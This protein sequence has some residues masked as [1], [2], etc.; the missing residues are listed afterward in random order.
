MLEM[1]ILMIVGFRI[2]EGLEKECIQRLLVYG[3]DCLVLYE[4]VRL[5]SRLMDAQHLFYP[6]MC[7]DWQLGWGAKHEGG[8]RGTNVAESSL[9]SLTG[10]STLSR[11]HRAVFEAHAVDAVTALNLLL[12][13]VLAV[14]GIC[15]KMRVE[16]RGA[17][18]YLVMD[19]CCE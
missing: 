7:L 10:C 8:E 6:T 15:V 14:A 17:A 2:Q 19:G 11:G 18:D 5:T 4:T 12:R 3:S 1:N 13:I 16:T 9:L